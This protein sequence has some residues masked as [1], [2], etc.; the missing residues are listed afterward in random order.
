MNDVTSWRGCN[1]RAARNPHRLPRAHIYASYRRARRRRRCLH[2]MHTRLHRRICLQ[3]SGEAAGPPAPTVS[4]HFGSGCHHAKLAFY[5]FR[6]RVHRVEKNTQC[7][8]RI[9]YGARCISGRSLL[10]RRT[11]KDLIRMQLV[12]YALPG[13]QT[14]YCAPKVHVQQNNRVLALHTRTLRTGDII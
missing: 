1:Q 7:D 13:A 6:R 9:L 10:W 2:K 8:A 4:L 12:Y 5:L 14:N 3:K 11:A